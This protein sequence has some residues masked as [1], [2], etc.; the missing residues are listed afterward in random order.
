MIFADTGAFVALLR[1]KDENYLAA[2]E[3]LAS[4][5]VLVTTDYVVDETVTLLLTRVGRKAAIRFLD[6]IQQSR[7]VRLDMVGPAG[8][9]EAADLFRAHND[10]TWSFTDC[11]SFAVMKRLG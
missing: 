8:F 10:K 11:A 6:A 3:F 5:P 7:F 2:K 4:R 9:R 1:E